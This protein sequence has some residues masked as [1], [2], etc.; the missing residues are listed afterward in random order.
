ML[1]VETR[2]RTRFVTGV[3]LLPDSAEYAGKI[4]GRLP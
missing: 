1:T 4:V 3:E 2:Y